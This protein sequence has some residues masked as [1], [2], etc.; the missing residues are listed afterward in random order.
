M[1]LIF[2]C[3]VAVGVEALQNPRFTVVQGLGHNHGEAGGGV[4]YSFQSRLS[5]P[6]EKLEGSSYSSVF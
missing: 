3:H 2:T 5:A 1:L 4:G 6:Q